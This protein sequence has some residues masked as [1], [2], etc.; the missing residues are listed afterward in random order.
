[1]STTI[2]ENDKNKTALLTGPVATARATFALLEIRERKE[3]ANIR[4]TPIFLTADSDSDY[5]IHERELTLKKNGD[6][7]NGRASSLNSILVPKNIKHNWPRVSKYVYDSYSFGGSCMTG[8][9]YVKHGE[10]TQETQMTMIYGG[11]ILYLN[12]NSQMTLPAMT[13]L[14]W[15][16]PYVDK[17]GYPIRIQ[18]ASRS[19]QFAGLILEP[20]PPTVD[21]AE[22]VWIY[23]GMMAYINSGTAGVLDEPLKEGAAHLLDSSISAA[24][25]LIEAMLKLTPHQQS[26]QAVLK[27]LSSLV[28]KKQ[29]NNRRN[30]SVELQRGHK[31][32]KRELVKYLFYGSAQL[33]EEI[34][35]DRKYKLDVA[36]EY[37]KGN[38]ITGYVTSSRS[39]NLFQ[40]RITVGYTND[41]IRPGETGSIYI[42]KGYGVAGGL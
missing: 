33:R 16:I 39:I 4:K 14:R 32:M 11:E 29:W 28:G 13:R 27:Q 21:S 10:G 6:S 30:V 38:S 42:G 17:R 19:E 37:Q 24:C 2:W 12:E 7:T 20:V 15:R 8:V 34:K 5:D 26:G 36:Q 3:N 41:E 31:Q 35:D 40:D 23:D 1:M 22:K 9:K 25:V 18:K